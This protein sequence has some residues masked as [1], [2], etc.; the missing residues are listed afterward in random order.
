MRV[1]GITRK[2]VN[3]EGFS[4]DPPNDMCPQAH[5][6]PATMPRYTGSRSRPSMTSL[7]VSSCAHVRVAAIPE[8]SFDDVFFSIIDIATGSPRVADVVEVH[9][10]HKRS[11]WCSRAKHPNPPA[12][13]RT[14]GSDGGGD[15][16]P[17]RYGAC[18]G[19]R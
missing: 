14:R 4:C 3:E 12:E 18:R 16:L 5:I 13:H 7:Y 15:S 9:R 17:S 19:A 11:A 6:Y 2:S 10:R 8:R 1:L